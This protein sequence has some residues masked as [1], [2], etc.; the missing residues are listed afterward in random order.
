MDLLAALTRL[1]AD[2]TLVAGVQAM[3]RQSEAQSLQ[4]AE[5]TRQLAQQ[6]SQ[7][8]LLELKNQQLVHELAY[9]KH[10]RFGAS[11]EAVKAT[12]HQLFEEDRLQDI[13][14]V[15]AELAQQPG[16]D[17]QPRPR[18]RRGAGRQPLP[19]HLERVDVRHELASCQ[20]GCCQG[21]L[22]LIG[23]DIS[24]Q[25]DIEPSRFFVLRHIRPQYACRTCETVEAAPLAPAVI[26]GSMATPR[27]LAWVATSKYLDHLPLYRIERIAN[28]AGVSL[29]SSTLSEWIGRIGVSL[30]PLADRLAERLRA[31]DSLHADETPVQ[32]LDPGKGKT[33]RAY[34]WA[35]RSNDLSGSPPMVV[36]D[37]QVSR[38]GQHVR[39]FLQ[40]WHGHLMVDDY[41]AYKALFRAG[42]PEQ[43]CWA[44]ARR[45]FFEL[46]LNMPHPVASEA[47]R[48]I[49]QLYAIES[50]G[51]A[52]DR[53]A[54][55]RLREE[56]SRPALQSLHDWL[57]DAQ[58]GA[59]HGSALARAVD[60]TLRRWPALSSYADTGHLP[61][62]NNPVE[63]AIR[64]IALG[65]KNWLFAGS[66]RAG[67]RAAAIQS[68]L[69]TAKLNAL[70]PF[71]WLLATLEKLPAW[72]NS[73]IDEL[74]PLKR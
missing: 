37:Y 4:L 7:I 23:E 74:L 10:V 36:F 61:I 33:R 66:E 2:P 29:P 15:E 41:A 30:Q 56:Q 64:A 31:Q 6:S 17:G 62:D 58:A 34:L 13:A 53:P 40:D 72:P 73:R 67:R 47:L 45:K 26:D 9:L 57:L 22:T 39:N 18:Q 52:L 1:N 12:Q 70:D 27:L 24:E 42:L 51:R 38:G 60:Y 54:R 14:A 25:L 8:Q 63:N 46:Q 19:D 21:P 68:L 11:S 69:A 5:T 50:A 49:G 28:R 48:R 43:G 3:L 55:Q 59:A 16:A 44:H 32:Q 20:C 71:A 35:Y 65:K